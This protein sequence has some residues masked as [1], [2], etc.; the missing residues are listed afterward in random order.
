MRKENELVNTSQ[1][2]WVEWSFSYQQ[3]YQSYFGAKTR[4][5]QGEV[6]HFR[7]G[8]TLVA[9]ET[10]ALREAQFHIGPI[11]DDCLPQ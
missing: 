9:S 8:S 1:E 4:E 7:S 10:C 5:L 6:N 2:P 3:L 11:L